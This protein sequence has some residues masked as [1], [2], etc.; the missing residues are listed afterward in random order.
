MYLCQRAGLEPPIVLK[1]ASLWVKT[2][3]CIVERYKLL[4]VL[5]CIKVLHDCIMTNCINLLYCCHKKHRILKEIRCFS[6]FLGS[7]D[8]LKNAGGVSYGVSFLFVQFE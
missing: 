3:F 1:T 7:N 5:H 6:N 8:E 4:K 2:M